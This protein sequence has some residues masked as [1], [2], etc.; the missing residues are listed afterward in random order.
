MKLANAV[1]FGWQVYGYLA[2]SLR[3]GYCCLLAYDLT[4]MEMRQVVQLALAAQYLT[5]GLWTDST[6]Y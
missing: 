3:S 4:V 2:P 6:A 5:S 1:L